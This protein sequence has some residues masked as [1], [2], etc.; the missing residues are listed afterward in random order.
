MRRRTKRL[1]AYSRRARPLTTDRQSVIVAAMLETRAGH[2]WRLPERAH[3]VRCRDDFRADD[4][5]RESG[6]RRASARRCAAG[7]AAAPARAVLLG[8]VTA[9]MPIYAR[10]ILHTGPWGLGILCEAPRRWVRW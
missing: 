4:G 7:R 1:H 5:V 2:L 9:P 10:D 8:A 3:D 6:L